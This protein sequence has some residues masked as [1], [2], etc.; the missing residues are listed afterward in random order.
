MDKS[1]QVLNLA[2]QKTLHMWQSVSTKTSELLRDGVER[3]T[4]FLRD[5]VER[6]TPFL[7]DVKDKSWQTAHSIGA[8]VA[9]GRF[10]DI[11]RADITV[12]A[13]VV[14]ALYSAYVFGLVFYRL[15]LHPLAK[16][17]GYR[18]CAA[19]EWYEFYCYIVK[20][21]QWGNEIRK[22]HEKYGKK[23]PLPPPQRKENATTKVF[24]TQ[25]LT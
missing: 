22:M 9:E 6:A 15:Y 5:G 25:L 14:L 3:A 23:L 12:V 18:I 17:P 8:K 4:P 11:D 24:R 19:S 16:F 20:G 21:G 1:N 10:E 2:S 7:L 13:S